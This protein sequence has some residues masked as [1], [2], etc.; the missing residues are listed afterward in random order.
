MLTNYG[1]RFVAAVMYAKGKAFIGAAVLLD[2]KDGHPAVVLHLLCQGIEI[3][4]KSML[5][6][7]DYTKYGPRL[8]KIG[9]NLVRV[10]ATVRAASGLHVFSN[11]ALLHELTQANQFYKDQSLRYASKFDINIDPSTIPSKRLLRHI[12]A[13]I[14]YLERIGYFNE[15]DA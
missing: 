13:I 2:Q 1:Q 11:G 7:I 4:L 6:R 5:L 9:H 10:A 15:D 8:K 14:Q 3:I 12:T